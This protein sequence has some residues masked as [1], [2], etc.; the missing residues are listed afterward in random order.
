MQ[1]LG[2][3]N[4]LVPW[5]RRQAQPLEERRHF[6]RRHYEF[7]NT[8]PYL[9]NFV[10]GGLLRLESDRL[11]FGAP[12][13]HT[14]RVFRDSL[15]RAFASIGDQLFWLGVRPTLLLAAATCVVAGWPN[16]A[17]LLVG[18][19]ALAELALR[20]QALLSGFRHGFQLVNVLD[21]PAWYRAI[22]V[23]KDA[24]KLL[25]GVVAG[26]FFAR[27]LPAA[28]GGNELG[29]ILALVLAAALPP[30]IRKRLPGEVLLLLAAI[31]AVGLAFGL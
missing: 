24:G 1:N 23:L 22:P 13:T 8:N 14:I 31:V 3:L 9:A 10:I 7:F 25:T 6:C 17:L 29:A 19:F 11:R 18:I 4:T 20:W 2:L 15:G 5:L 21:R 28:S 16:G 26:C 12:D 30:V 27:I